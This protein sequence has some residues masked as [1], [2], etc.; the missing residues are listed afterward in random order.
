MDPPGTSKKP[1][2]SLHFQL[3][4]FL[5]CTQGSDYWGVTFWLEKQYFAFEIIVI[6]M[7][8]FASEREKKK[9]N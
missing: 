7:H 8:Q 4:I 1:D 5:M 2:T 6:L 3:S 9:K